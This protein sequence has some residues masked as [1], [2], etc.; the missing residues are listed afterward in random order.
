[1]KNIK[2]PQ[3]R[4]K[5]RQTILDELKKLTTHPTAV[6]MYEIVRETLPNISLGT[7]YRNLEMLAANGNIVKLKFGTSARFDGNSSR[8]YH[9][10]CIH[11]GEVN[12]IDE[13]PEDFVKQDFDK[14]GGYK[15]VGCKV[16]FVGI[17]PTC[18]EKNI[19]EVS[20]V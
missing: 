19:N 18:S 1:M 10:R 5:Q 11:C 7:V 20:Q 16:E 13:L 17:C 14:L 9:V 15:I 8:H 2:R 6:E 3:R 4:S 12:D